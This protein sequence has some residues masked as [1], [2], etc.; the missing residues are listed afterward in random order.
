MEEKDEHRIIFEH[1]VMQL[2]R[3]VIYNA[4][5]LHS[6]LFDI[7]YIV[8]IVQDL[9]LRAEIDEYCDQGIENYLIHNAY[10]I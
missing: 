9:I 4:G 7:H 3:L 1:Y 10:I 5:I 6:K 8:E 2:I